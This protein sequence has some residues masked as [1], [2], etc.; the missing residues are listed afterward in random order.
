MR[1]NPLH[2]RASLRRD[3]TAQRPA[4]VGADSRLHRRPASERRA[5]SMAACRARKTRW[6]VAAR[7]RD[8]VRKVVVQPPADGG[9]LK[10]A[11]R[12]CAMGVPRPGARH[13]C[14]GG[15][16]WYVTNESMDKRGGGSPRSKPAKL[17]AP[18]NHPR[19]SPRPWSRI[20]LDNQ[21]LS[22]FPPPPPAHPLPRSPRPP[23]L[24]APCGPPPPYPQACLF[25]GGRGERGS[26]HRFCRV[27]DC[28][29]RI[30]YTGP[31]S[32]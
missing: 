31:R 28:M 4:E 7:A 17:T 8:K 9:A 24:C 5:A 22:L 21:S 10:W 32:A 16:Q 27:P 30:L 19:L 18:E 1:R 12:A 20:R 6:Q 23:S 15:L 11:G 13:A 25:E 29:G 3:C 2:A 14:G 26:E